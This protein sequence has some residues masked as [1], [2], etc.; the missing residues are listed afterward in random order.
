[1]KGKII[2]LIL[3]LDYVVGLP[4]LCRLP[5]GV[6][7]ATQYIPSGDDMAVGLAL[8]FG[9][10]AVVGF[11]LFVTFLLRSYLPVTFVVSFLV[12]TGVIIFFHYDFDLSS[13]A[14]AAIGLF[15]HPVLALPIVGS[16]TGVS[17][18]LE[19]VVRSVRRDSAAEVS[20]T[21]SHQ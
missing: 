2:G 3:L 16:V 1:V 18:L 8:L 21:P 7:F 12:T 11:P 14:Q 15:M 10:F 13:D 6:A 4:F 17:A 9:L 20:Q 5:R 19:F